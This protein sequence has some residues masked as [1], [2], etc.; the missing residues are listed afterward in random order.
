M[1]QS[2]PGELW[3]K[4]LGDVGLRFGPSFRKQI[5]VES[6][7]DARNSRVLLSLSDPESAF[8]QSPYLIHPACIDG[9]LQSGAPS[10]WQGDRSSIDTLLVPAIIDD[11]L[12]YPRS[13]KPGDGIA[14]TTSEYTGV[15]NPDEVKNF[16]THASVYDSK[17][18]SLVLK[19]SGL[20]Y[21]E[22]NA[23]KH[24]HGSHTYARLT[25]RPDVSFISE[26]QLHSIAPKEPTVITAED[27]NPS[28]MELHHMIEMIAHKKPNLAVMEVN[29]NSGS[30]STWLEGDIFDESLRAGCT[31]YRI[32]SNTSSDLLNAQTKFGKNA[33]VE[34][35]ICDITKPAHEFDTT[36]TGFDLLIV[37]LV[38]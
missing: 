12:L 34:F 36:A 19:M 29:M 22:L 30:H 38:S 8:P 14:V 17:S 21:N 35:S 32:T 23:L 5:E 25:W 15:G 33:I 11:I 16:M 24:A 31:R 3:Y 9:C 26:Q 28:W 10:F 7:A 20:R 2:V 4:A 6:L 18:G 37:K 27:R 13:T 1:S